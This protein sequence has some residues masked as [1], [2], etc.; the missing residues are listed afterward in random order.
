MSIKMR[1]DALSIF[2]WTL[3]QLLH[4]GAILRLPVEQSDPF[5]LRSERAASLSHHSSSEISLQI[6]LS[7]IFSLQ[8]QRLNP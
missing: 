5:Q 4:A 6:R 1:D 8:Q 3:K 2:N 7:L